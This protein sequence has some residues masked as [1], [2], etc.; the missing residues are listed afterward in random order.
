MKC[1]SA[2]YRIH[3]SHFLAFNS[4]EYDYP[5]ADSMII[6]DTDQSLCVHEHPSK[7]VVFFNEVDEAK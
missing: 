2:A 3:R 6:I 4:T 5:T 7:V 1:V